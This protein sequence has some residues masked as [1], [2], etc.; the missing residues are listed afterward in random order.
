MQT[1]KYMVNA[2]RYHNEPER[3]TTCTDIVSHNQGYDRDNLK[4]VNETNKGGVGG[5]GEKKIK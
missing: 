5:G 2:S 1:V 3:A 4:D